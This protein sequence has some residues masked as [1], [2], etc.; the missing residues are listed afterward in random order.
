MAKEK[1]VQG[2]ID[3]L[4][5]LHKSKETEVEDGI[6]LL[7][8]ALAD[9][10][11]E[12]DLSKGKEEG[13]GDGSGKDDEDGDEG[14]GGEGKEEKDGEKDGED[15]DDFGKSVDD[16]VYE[17]LVK[18]SEAYGELTTSVVT[19]GEKV[20]T[21]TKSQTQTAEDVAGLM[22]AVADLTSLTKSIGKGLVFLAKSVSEIARQPGKAS[23]VHLS[24]EHHDHDGGAI[25]KSKSEV[26]NLIKAAVDNGD[27]E[28][29]DARWLSQVAVHGPGCLPE[30]IK[31][32]IGL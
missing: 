20:E 15:G 25:T 10:D 9:F 28:K 23:A 14:K 3:D 24:G 8:K 7:E 31:K 11:L 1:D 32:T 29:A 13:E 21:L 18:A 6:S 30:D 17:E 19:V 12:D 4:D 27:L 16:G 5:A 22:A 26:C 2:V